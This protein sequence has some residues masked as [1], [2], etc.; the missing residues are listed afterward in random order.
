MEI[1]FATPSDAAAIREIYKPS[2]TDNAVS[3][4]EAM[5]SVDE[6]RARI[7]K[8]S[9]QYP[10][11][12]ATENKKILGYAYANPFRERAS[13]RWCVEVTVYLHEDAKR[14]GVGTALY[15]HLH[16]LLKK[17]GYLNG[18]AGITLPND[19]SIRLH[20]K[21]GYTL[22]GVYQNAGFKLGQWHDVARYALAINTVA[23]LSLPP[24]EPQPIAKIPVSF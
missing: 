1:R 11:L 17:Q 23:E 20:E 10:Y 16:T 3:F 6:M 24:A 15:T 22:L 18:L 2:V 13:Y 9:A 7:E 4:E 21:F 8:I 12:V 19:A 5:P 14:K